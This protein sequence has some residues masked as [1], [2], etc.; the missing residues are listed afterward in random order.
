MN[1]KFDNMGSK[2]YLIDNKHT[3]IMVNLQDSSYSTLKNNHKVVN[4]TIDGQNSLS[5]LY[6][7][8]KSELFKISFDR[9]KPE[10]VLNLNMSKILAFERNYLRELLLVLDYKLLFLYDLTKKINNTENKIK[11]LKAGYNEV[12]TNA[13]FMSNN[14][15]IVLIVK[16]NLIVT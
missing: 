12:F 5:L 13:C 1:C 16:V 3:L 10:K 8:P 6:V 11:S 4:F 2:L 9:K 7:S 15:F 14:R